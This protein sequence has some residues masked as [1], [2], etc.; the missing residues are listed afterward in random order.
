M[1]YSKSAKLSDGDGHDPTNA[2]EVVHF[3]VDMLTSLQS[4]ASARNLTLLAHLIE[5]A[6]LEALK[7]KG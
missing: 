3:I 5:L 1:A 4:I 6:K 7:N 2:P